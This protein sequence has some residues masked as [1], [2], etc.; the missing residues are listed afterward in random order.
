MMPT[1]Q[2]VCGPLCNYR[3][4]ELRIKSP[5]SSLNIANVEEVIILLSCALLAE[6]GL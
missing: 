2:N 4:E 6:A 1:A 5:W 3:I